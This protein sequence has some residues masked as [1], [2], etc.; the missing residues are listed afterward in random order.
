MIFGKIAYLHA[1]EIMLAYTWLGDLKIRCGANSR[2]E[3]FGA[4]GR[5]DRCLSS[6]PS[7]RPCVQCN[8]KIHS[9]FPF[10]RFTLASGFHNS[11]VFP[12]S[13]RVFTSVQ[14]VQQIV[15]TKCLISKNIATLKGLVI[16]IISDFPPK[17]ALVRVHSFTPPLPPQR[18]VLLMLYLLLKW[19]IDTAIKIYGLSWMSD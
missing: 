18:N 6:H 9:I 8:P 17:N 4:K 2:W 16:L 14:P 13:G 1:G 10:F 12:F 11:S 5:R 3:R 19:Q 15:K 7:A